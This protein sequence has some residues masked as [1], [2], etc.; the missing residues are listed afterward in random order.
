MVKLFITLYLQKYFPNDTSIYNYNFSLENIQ[1]FASFLIFK[2][3]QN[4]LN[5]IRNFDANNFIF[6]FKLFLREG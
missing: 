5:Y 1:I 2:N 4:C 3:K 6:N